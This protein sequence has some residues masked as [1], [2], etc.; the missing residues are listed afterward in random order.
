MTPLMIIGIFVVGLALIIVLMPF[1]IGAGGWLQDAAVGDSFER[2][3]L[4]RK[5]ILKR[6]IDEEAQH[7]TGMLTDREWSL[8]QIYLTNRYVDVTRRMDWLAAEE[9]QKSASGGV[10]S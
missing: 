10:V 9:S 8:R 6:W 7:Q 1:F 3:L 2:L 4:R 5:A